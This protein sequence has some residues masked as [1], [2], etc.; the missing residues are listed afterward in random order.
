L[1]IAHLKDREGD[2]KIM[3]R[4]DLLTALSFCTLPATNSRNGAAMETT[5]PLH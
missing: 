5:Y 2:G 1:E 3:F 4:E